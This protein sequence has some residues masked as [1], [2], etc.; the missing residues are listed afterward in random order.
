LGH[1][2]LVGVLRFFLWSKF[3]SHVASHYFLKPLLYKLLLPPTITSERLRTGQPWGRR[4]PPKRPFGPRVSAPCEPDL[5]RV[6]TAGDWV[7]LLPGAALHSVRFSRPRLEGDP[8][9]LA[10]C[11]P[12]SDP[13]DASRQAATPWSLP[14]PVFPALS[15][16]RSQHPQAESR[17][18][19]LRPQAGSVP[20]L[21]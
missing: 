6:R 19:R 2:S 12:D 13:Q 1:V 4:R 21:S 8:E 5:G 9:S 17:L 20:F 15:A 18:P 7:F 3:S 16:I 10:P 14:P 11:L